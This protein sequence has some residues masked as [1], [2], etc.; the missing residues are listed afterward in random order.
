MESHP[1]MD[2]KSQ[3]GAEV[4]PGPVV[5]GAGLRPFH[6]GENVGIFD[7]NF[8]PQPFL[9]ARMTGFSAQN[10]VREAVDKESLI[11][12][13]MPSIHTKIF[14]AKDQQIANS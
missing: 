2:F 7:V 1:L 6:L 4:Q 14:A 13:D 10:F 12:G 8:C 11:L 9:L 3:K 5:Q